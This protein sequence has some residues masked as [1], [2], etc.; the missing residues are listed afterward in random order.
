MAVWKLQHNESYEQKP[1]LYFA[2]FCDQSVI[3]QLDENISFADGLEITSIPAAHFRSGASWRKLLQER[4]ELAQR[5]E[6]APLAVVI[7]GTV[8]HH[9]DLDYLREA[10]DVMASLLDHGACAVYDVLTLHW[11]SEK[12]WRILTS[13]GAIFNPFDHIMTSAQ[14]ESSGNFW[15]CTKGLRKFGRPDLVVREVPQSELPPVEKMLDRFV[16]FQSLG[17]IIEP[18]REVSMDGLS[19][20]YR[21]SLPQGDVESAPYFNSFVELQ[22]SRS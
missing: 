14:P 7:H 2:A 5:I 16:N 20:V 17:G 1:Y 3:D 4:P 21:T 15:V 12:D 11:W 22:P 18:D 8:T 6:E 9:E 10:I 19:G 13:D